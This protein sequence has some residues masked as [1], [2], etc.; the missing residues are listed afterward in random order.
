MSQ[1]I[2]F[3]PPQWAGPAKWYVPAFNSGSPTTAESYPSSK[4]FLKKTPSQEFLKYIFSLWNHGEWTSLSKSMRHTRHQTLYPSLS[5]LP[6][7]KLRQ[8][9]ISFSA[10]VLWKM[11]AVSNNY[12]MVIAKIKWDDV[13][14]NLWQN[15]SAQ[16][17]FFPSLK[18]SFH[19]KPRLREVSNS[20][21]LY[22]NRHSYKIGRYLGI[23]V[24]KYVKL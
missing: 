8:E 14:N 5:I 2:E 3:S 22:K 21:K 10:F 4:T 24:L 6:L 15:R 19:K 13:E 17:L 7:W 9:A 11:E 18:F 1:I 20:L 12:H 16:Y 23:S